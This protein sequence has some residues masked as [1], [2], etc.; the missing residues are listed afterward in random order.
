MLA[1]NDVDDLPLT[2]IQD[3]LAI[4]HLNQIE[5]GTITSKWLQAMRDPTAGCI[6]QP[7]RLDFGDRQTIRHRQRLC[8]AAPPLG[9]RADV[10]LVEPQPTPGEGRRG[11]YRKAL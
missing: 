8:F 7:W 6:G 5:I 1:V 2:Q 9:R 4:F 11:E 10:R 3:Y